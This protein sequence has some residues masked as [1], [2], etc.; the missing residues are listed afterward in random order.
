MD[1]KKARSV[2]IY[3]FGGPEVLRIDAL[4][5][6]INHASSFEPDGGRERRFRGRSSGSERNLGSVEPDGMIL[7]EARSKRML[8][9]HTHSVLCR[10]V[11]REITS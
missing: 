4:S 8:S 5:Y 6:F 1:E 11:L 7:A 3:D 2:R 9:R 10:M